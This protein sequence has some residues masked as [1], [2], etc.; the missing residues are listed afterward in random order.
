MFTI[1]I[2]EPLSVP[3]ENNWDHFDPCRPKFIYKKFKDI[4]RYYKGVFCSYLKN[5]FEVTFYLQ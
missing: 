4:I 1:P 5:G 3:L 2:Q